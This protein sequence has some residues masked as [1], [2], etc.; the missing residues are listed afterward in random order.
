MA[1]DGGCPAPCGLVGLDEPPAQRDG[2]KHQLLD[3]SWS[4]EKRWRYPDLV[5]RRP[6]AMLGVNMFVIF[7]IVGIV[8]AAGWAE[9]TPNHDDDFTISETKA[10][11]MVDAIKLSQKQVDKPGNASDA[12]VRRPP[13]RASRRAGLI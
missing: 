13:E 9:L 6:C 1:V 11:N 10:S 3:G 5:A 4:N 12:R 8:G 7:V 2:T